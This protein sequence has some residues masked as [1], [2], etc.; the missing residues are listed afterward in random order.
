M[1]VWAHLPARTRVF[2]PSAL[3]SSVGFREARTGTFGT[4]LCLRNGRHRSSGLHM[5][6]SPALC[7]AKPH[8]GEPCHSPHVLKKEKNKK[9][10]DRHKVKPSKILIGKP[11]LPSSHPTAGPLF[12]TCPSLR[13][14]H[15]STATP[16][17]TRHRTPPPNT[18][19][20]TLTDT[21]THC[22]GRSPL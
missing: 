9:K 22:R 10:P 1:T 6:R 20:H 12:T 11:S 17:G 13:L 7:Q 15:P 3:L 2:V 14:R 21:H 19:T 5:N 4:S 16:R 18:H 8:S